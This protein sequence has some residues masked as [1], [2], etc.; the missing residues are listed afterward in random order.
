MDIRDAAVAYLGVERVQLNHLW[1]ADELGVALDPGAAGVD[2]RVRVGQ[3]VEHAWSVSPTHEE[4]RLEHHGCSPGS[5]TGEDL[6]DESCCSYMARRGRG[7][8]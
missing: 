5:K 1:V 3:H 2:I 8:R 4:R 6:G 7:G